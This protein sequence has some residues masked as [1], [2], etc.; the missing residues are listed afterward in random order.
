MKLSDFSERR[1]EVFALYDKKESD[2]LEDIRILREWMSKLPHLPN[3]M[4]QDEF[5][6]ICLLKN[7]FSMEKSKAKIE[8]YC[9][10]KGNSHYDYIYE[11]IPVPSKEPSSHIPIPILTDEYKRLVFCAIHDVNAFE[12]DTDLNFNAVIREFFLRYDYNDGEIVVI[13]LRNCP[14]SIIRKFRVNICADGIQLILQGYSTRLSAIH[15]I[16][17][18]GRTI[19]AVVMPLLPKKLVSRLHFHDDEES[20]R[21]VI[22]AKY[23]PSD[24][25]GDL[26]SLQEIRA[27]W[28]EI[29]I[30]NRKLIRS[31][32]DTKSREELRQGG[33]SVNEEL[34]GT[35]RKFNLD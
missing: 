34:K 19:V 8:M 11:R 3:D 27:D 23:L 25:G 22:P 24:F 9:T 14:S 35:F 28:D 29:F 33:D 17:R 15:V 2:V 12:M 4:I 30:E 13:D 6:E 16:S 32:V 1:L 10:L 7:K 31:F 5:L 20:L 21:R 26:K 18:I